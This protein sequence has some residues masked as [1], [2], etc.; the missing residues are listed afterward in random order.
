MPAASG[1]AVKRVTN[2][3]MDAGLEVRTVPP[4]HELFDGTIDPTRARRVRVED[5]LPPAVA[6]EHAAGCRSDSSATAPS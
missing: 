3:A 6:T 4:M 1:L 2:A 5:L